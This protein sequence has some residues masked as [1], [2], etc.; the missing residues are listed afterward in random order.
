MHCILTGSAFVLDFQILVG[1]RARILTKHR[2]TDEN[3]TE[4]SVLTLIHN[5]LEGEENGGFNILF[6]STG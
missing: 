5:N 1:P 4:T 2:C 3:F 6:A